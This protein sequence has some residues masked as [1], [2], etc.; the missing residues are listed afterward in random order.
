MLTLLQPQKSK[1]VGE[2]INF[3]RGI[4]LELKDMRKTVSMHTCR[5][6]RKENYTDD[7]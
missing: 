4:K 6:I 1:L 7:C 2:W 3:Q 5:L